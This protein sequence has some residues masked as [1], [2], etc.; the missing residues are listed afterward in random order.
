MLMIRPSTDGQA[1]DY[2]S[3]MNV[4]TK[5]A[6]RAAEH[7]TY[8]FD[9]GESREGWEFWEAVDERLVQIAEGD[10][11]TDEKL[12][13]SKRESGTDNI[14]DLIVDPGNVR[15]ARQALSEAFDWRVAPEGHAFWN[16]VDQR[17]QELEAIGLREE[18]KAAALAP[19]AAAIATPPP[20]PFW[21]SLAAVA[22]GLAV[23]AA[24]ALVAG[25]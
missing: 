11:H 15:A 18:A 23:V 9:W 22:L 19:Q 13:F 1:S 20:R 10:W 16:S 14:A 5:A 8:A 25:D 6:G 4:D 12:S 24:L 17:L 3:N 2:E 7:L 21:R